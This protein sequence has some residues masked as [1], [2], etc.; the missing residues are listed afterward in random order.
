MEGYKVSINRSGKNEYFNTFFFS[1]TTHEIP[2]QIFT[3]YLVFIRQY[4]ITRLHTQSN[5]LKSAPKWTETI[6][7]VEE[8]YFNISLK[9]IF[10]SRNSSAVHWLQVKKNKTIK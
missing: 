1:R 7:D 9:N 4:V 6:E 8:F 5:N 2:Q 10:L 3:E